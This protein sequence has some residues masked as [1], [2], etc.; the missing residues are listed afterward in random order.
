LLTTAAGDE[1]MLLATIDPQRVA[2]VR[3]RFG[4]LDDRR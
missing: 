3:A 2:D 1:T 4:F